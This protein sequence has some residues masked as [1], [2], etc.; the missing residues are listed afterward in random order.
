MVGWAGRHTLESLSIKS[1]GG[2]EARVWTTMHT[3]K[4]SSLTL[5]CVDL[6]RTHKISPENTPYVYMALSSELGHETPDHAATGTDCH[7]AALW[8][9]LTCKPVITPKKWSFL[10]SSE[11]S[12]QRA[13]AVLSYIV[14]IN[15]SVHGLQIPP[16]PQFPR[17]RRCSAQ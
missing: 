3:E 4:S 17:T 10:R 16:A 7:L 6:S 2:E 14:A 11:G 1:T 8:E 13:H 5:L 15:A 12:V 9:P